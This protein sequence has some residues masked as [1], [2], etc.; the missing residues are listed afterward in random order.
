[1]RR[2]LIVAIGLALGVMIGRAHAHVHDHPE[3]DEW[4]ASQQT[5]DDRKW[6]CCN[7]SDAYLLEDDDVRIVEGEYEVKTDQGWLR[8]PNTGQGR[9]GNTVMGYS[10]NPTGHAVAWYIGG[11]AFCFAEGTSA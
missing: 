5:P 8:F 2:V 4:F 3:W 10:R 7:K 1:M 6:S 11:T 9:E